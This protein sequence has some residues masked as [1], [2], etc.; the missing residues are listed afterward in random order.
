[1]YNLVFKK[2]K[3]TSSFRRF[4]DYTFVDNI[5]NF[6][7]DSLLFDEVVLQ[8][9]K[10]FG[11]SNVCV[12][13]YEYLS[14][15]PRDY[16]FKLSEFIGIDFDKTFDLLGSNKKN[17]RSSLESNIYKTDQRS[18]LEILGYLKA[19]MPIL[20]KINY[21]KYGSLYTLLAN[22]PIGNSKN[23]KLEFDD[24][25][26]DIMKNY[27]SLGNQSLSTRHSLDLHQFGYF[28]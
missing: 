23:L 9:E 8:Y 14:I 18:A 28:L 2:F 16:V 3:P 27:Y 4:C 12:L 1:M 13:P 19:R 24:H 20:T 22:L 5:D 11:R 7:A 15:N 10:L 26:F 6:L 21:R 25:I 17:N